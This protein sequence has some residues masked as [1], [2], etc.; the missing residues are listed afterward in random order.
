MTV[1]TP[2]TRSLLPAVNQQTWWQPWFV[3][4]KIA[5]PED[6]DWLAFSRTSERRDFIGSAGATQ[7]HWCR[8]VGVSMAQDLGLGY[9]F[10]ISTKVE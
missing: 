9:T 7:A 10:D 6:Q 1:L 3:I 8:E 4:Q 2:L 5:W